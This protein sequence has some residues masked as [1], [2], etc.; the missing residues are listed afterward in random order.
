MHSTA[1]TI[2]IIGASRVGKSSIKDVVIGDKFN[3]EKSPTI[4]M[5]EIPQS[6]SRQ[7]GNLK[8]KYNIWDC[9]GQKVLQHIPVLYITGAMAVLIVYDLTDNVT[10]KR[11]KEWMKYVQDEG[12]GYD[13]VLVIGNKKDLINERVVSYEEAH[14]CC[15]QFGYNYMET[16]AKSGINMD[17]LQKWLDSHTQNKV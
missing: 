13:K 14:N 10:Y 15:M 1:Q 12:K 6:Y 4:R 9:P 8:V 5:T 11:A 17:T 16:S 7:I 3:A 2:T